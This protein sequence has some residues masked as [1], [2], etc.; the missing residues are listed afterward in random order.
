[1]KHLKA[2]AHAWQL[3]FNSEPTQ[4]NNLLDT[5]STCYSS[6]FEFNSTPD[7]GNIEILQT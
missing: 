4:F 7:F 5:N 3:Q 1:M 6:L 2:K